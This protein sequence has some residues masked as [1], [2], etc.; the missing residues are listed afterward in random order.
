MVATTTR[1]H[2]QRLKSY[3]EFSKPIY[4]YLLW[5]AKHL[6]FYP[7]DKKVSEKEAQLL[8]HDL[9]AQKLKLSASMKVLDAGCGE[10][11]VSTYLAKKYGCSIDGIT[12]V[13]FEVKR[14]TKRAEKLGIRDKVKFSLMDY[15]NMSFEDNYFDAIYTIESLVHSINLRNTLHEFY[16]VLRTKGKISLFEYSP[17]DDSRFSDHERD[18]LAKVMHSAAMPNLMGFQID[19]LEKTL[20]DVGFR[21]IQIR[22]ITE[23]IAPSVLRL[24]RYFMVPYFFVNMFGLHSKCPNLTGIVEFSRMGEKG[25]MTY[26]TVS[27]EK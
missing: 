20:T 15:S 23:N 11:I 7:K 8:M 18:L 2:F 10:G 22:D 24:R 6:G 16:R 25:L 14:A 21:N 1:K 4:D 27:A 19:N 17:V 9:I 13:P 26:K 3:F 12:V 5:G